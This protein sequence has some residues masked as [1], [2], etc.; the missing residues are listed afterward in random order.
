VQAARGGSRVGDRADS[1]SL[2]SEHGSDRQRQ[3]SK[4]ERGPEFLNPASVTEPIEAGFD[5]TLHCQYQAPHV[6][7]CGYISTESGR[8]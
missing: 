1:R 7:A 3:A 6:V 8:D 2:R 5:V 4:V